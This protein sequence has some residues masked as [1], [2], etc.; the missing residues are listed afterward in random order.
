[1]SKSGSKKIKIDTVTITDSPWY[2]ELS[3]ITDGI[4]VPFDSG[5]DTARLVEAAT[6]SRGS[7]EQ[8]ILF[9]KLSA[10]C[11]DPKLKRVFSS[12]S[13]VRDNMKS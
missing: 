13:I 9:D 8:R 5:E 12:Y 1:M 10:E 4:S 2:K 6:L 11:S 3:Q 7:V